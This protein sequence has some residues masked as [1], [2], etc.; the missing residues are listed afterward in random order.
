MGV[1]AVIKL[2]SRSEADRLGKR[3]S[4][5]LGGHGQADDWRPDRPRL[6]R[7]SFRRPRHR[8]P[9]LG[10][11]LVAMIATALVAA[12]AALG[13]WFMPFVL[14]VATGPA[15]RRGRW[16]LRV[17]VPAVA[18]MAAGG[19][20]LA[21]PIAALRGV[22]VGATARTI[23]DVAGLP[24]VAALVIAITLAVSVT[25]ALAGLWLGCAVDPL[26]AMTNARLRSRG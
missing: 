18:V 15:M 7:P 16:R 11:L 12:G 6:F 22:P 26:M 4:Y 9:V 20:A 2:V 24:A 1:A 14:G 23:A 13:L 3:G 5:Q 19:W 25:Q 8:G 10:W 21:L 17:I